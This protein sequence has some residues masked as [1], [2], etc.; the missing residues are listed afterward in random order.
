MLER[1]SGRRKAGRPRIIASWFSAVAASMA[2][3]TSL[4]V[5]LALNGLSLSRGEIRA[6]YRNKTLQALY[7]QAREEFLRANYGR[8]PTLRAKFGR[9][10]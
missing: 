7:Q 3:G 10:L 5:A 6:S 2:D 9:Y 1:P 4:K 8:K